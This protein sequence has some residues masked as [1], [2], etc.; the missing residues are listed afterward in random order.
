ME[1]IYQRSL[2]LHRLHRGKLEIK[3]KV[4]LNSRDDLSLAYTPGVAEICRAIAKDKTQTRE[5]TIKGKE[6]FEK[7]EKCIMCSGKNQLNFTPNYEGGFRYKCNGGCE[8]EYG[9]TRKNIFYKVPGL[10]NIK[11]NLSNSSIAINKGSLLN[12]IGFEYI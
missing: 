2:D 6:H 11:M 4:A 7:Y 1:E 12:A 9:F 3:S 5:L 8:V 10:D